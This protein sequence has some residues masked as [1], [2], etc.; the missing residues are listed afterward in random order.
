MNITLEKQENCQALLRVEISSETVTSERSDIVKAF[1]RQARLPG[2]RPGKAPKAV[3][4]KRFAREIGEELDSRLIRQGLQEAVEKES[5]KVLSAPDPA[6]PTHHSDG[7]FSFSSQLVL[8]PDFELPD[9]KD[10]TLEIPERKIE[11]S[12]IDQELERLRERFADFEE[13]ADRPLAEGDFAIVDYQASAEGKSIEEAYG[14]SAPQLDSGEDF[15]LKMDDESFLPGFAGQLEGASPGDS[16]TVKVMIEEDYPV[17]ELRGKDIDFAVTVKSIRTQ[18][19]PE[20]TDEF[21]AQIMPNSTLDQLKELIREQMADHLERQLR[22]F[23]TSQ[24]L[25][26][27]SNQVEFD[28]PPEL[29]ANETQNQADRLVEQGL[30]SGMSEEEI[31]D[32]QGDLF[33]TAG[34]QARTNLKTDFLLQEIALAE[35]IKVEPAEL[36]QQVAA[37]A[38]QMNKP[39]KTFARDLQRTGRLQGLQHQILLGKTIDFLLEQAKVENVPAEDANDSDNE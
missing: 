29:V 31:A 39:V 3:I 27:I 9:Y 17:E 12:D 8:A 5:L 35:E 37:Y 34:Q 19:L 1:S 22:E 18:N 6:D 4:E 21:A 2:F 23:K 38:K 11:D 32:R 7:T 33:A 13:V 30:G 28:L 26:K 14:A 36:Q 20:L 25:E 16:R 15:W 24:L 10:L